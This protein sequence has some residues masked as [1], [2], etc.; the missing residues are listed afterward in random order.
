MLL[1]CRGSAQGGLWREGL[2]ATL[3]VA[4]SEIAAE[5][6]RGEAHSFATLGCPIFLRLPRAVRQA[7]CALRPLASLGLPTAQG[8]G[9]IGTHGAPSLPQSTLGSPFARWTPGGGGDQNRH[10]RVLP[11]TVDF[12][13]AVLVQHARRPGP[14][15]EPQEGG[16][17]T[18]KKRVC[19]PLKSLDIRAV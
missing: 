1:I 13:T 10:S 3:K 2:V 18:S 7:P 17:S 15:P 12:A 14:F 11:Y 4:H 19:R 9:P 8:W 5:K 16:S 6:C